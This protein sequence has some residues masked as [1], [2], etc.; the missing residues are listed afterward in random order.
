MAIRAPYFQIHSILY[1]EEYMVGIC[2]AS[3]EVL[4]PTN[5]LLA[6]QG[7]LRT[8]VGGSCCRLRK[9]ACMLPLFLNLSSQEIYYARRDLK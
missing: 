3:V 7:H 8:R 4:R 1:E 6:F 2:L 9:N 5:L